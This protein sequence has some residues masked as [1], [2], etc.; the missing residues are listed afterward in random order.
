MLKEVI[1]LHL[2]PAIAGVGRAA[3]AWEAPV[4]KLLNRRVDMTSGFPST[5]N[6]AIV[7]VGLP[8]V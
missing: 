1:V 3:N 8:L 5:S 7:E 4:E 2:G 6:R